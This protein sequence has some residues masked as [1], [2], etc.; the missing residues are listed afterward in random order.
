MAKYFKLPVKDKDVKGSINGFLR[1]ILEKGLVHALLVPQEVPSGDNVVQTLVSDPETLKRA[2]PVSPVMGVHSSRIISKMT[3]QEPNSQKV[4][5]VLKPCEWR[6]LVE[7]VKLKQAS[8]ENMVVI[9]V[10]CP[11]TFPIKQYKK[12]MEEGASPDKELLKLIEG[13][14]QGEGQEA[15]LRTAC[16]VC[17]HFTPH[18][19]DITIGLFGMDLGNEILIAANTEEGERILNGLKL[20]CN[21]DIKEKSPGG[22][23]RRE[24]SIAK[25]MEQRIKKRD[26]LFAEVQKEIGSPDKLLAF[27]STCIKCHN[28]MGACPICY[29][30]ECFFESPT[31]E[32]EADRYLKW[33]DRKGAI[34]M[35]T[36]TLLFHLTRMNH[37]LLSCV[38]CGICEEA[39]PNDIP[40]FKVFRMFGHTV[41]QIFKYIPGKDLKEELPLSTFK[42]DE[43]K[44]VGE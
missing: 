26:E 42:E 15:N 22:K 38:G 3:K 8:L 18:G 33:A 44:D 40:L 16:Q 2:D 30:R 17:E 11:G 23:N 32:F 34:R 10:D 9:G 20:E 37:M 25:L 5:V 13:V 41:Q 12:M 19:T 21:E 31:F 29:C 27:F 35:P 28:C 43:L 1:D 7:L 39:C 36:D 24:E 4:A 14:G 6:A